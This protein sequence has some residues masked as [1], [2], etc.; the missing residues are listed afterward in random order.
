MNAVV[1]VER[2]QEQMKE[3]KLP[4][5]SEELPLLLQDAVKR[6]LSCADFLEEVIT[7]ELEARHDRLTAMKTAMA[8]FPFH[9][10]LESFDFSF[11]PSLKPKVI[12][13][14]AKG[15]FIADAD[16]ILFLGPPGVGKTHLAVG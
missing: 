2:L 8:R 7:R 15:R 9:K 14:L 6:D 10:S 11:H 4:R 13:E 5:A 3:L 12:H 1:Q 16:N